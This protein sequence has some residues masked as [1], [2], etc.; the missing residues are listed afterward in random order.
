MEEGSCSRV[1]LSADSKTTAFEA[2]EAVPSP[3][4]RKDTRKLCPELGVGGVNVSILGVH[5][6]GPINKGDGAKLV[7]VRIDH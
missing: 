1:T 7:N 4:G 5:V 6:T 2:L 3:T